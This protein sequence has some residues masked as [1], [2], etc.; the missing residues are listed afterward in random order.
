MNTNQRGILTLAYGKKRYVNMAK[1]LGRSLKLHNHGVPC[2]I[3]TDSDDPELKNLYDICI[4][5]NQ[6]FGKG[7]KQKLYIDNYSPFDE[8]IFIDSDCIVIKKIDFWDIFADVPFGVISEGKKQTGQAFWNTIPDVEKII[9][10]FQLESLT[11]FNGGLYYFKNNKD[12]AEV[13]KKAR[14]I[15]ANYD[16]IGLVRLRG[17]S[18]EEPIYSIALAVCGI[19][20]I[21]DR[22]LTMRTP[23][24]MIGS[25]EI[26]VLKGFCRFNSN[27]QIVEPAIMHFCGSQT[28]GF[29]YQREKLK[30]YLANQLPNINRHLIA[31]QINLIFLPFYPAAV[32]T[33]IL[34]RTVKRMLFPS[35][36]TA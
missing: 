1:V 28:S 29:Y 17:S 23:I 5:L 34:R 10:L 26:D 9:S 13:F 18:N 31:N 4:P 16:E 20:G 36:P 8:T 35:L 11:M 12:T 19:N 33:K 7:F 32:G 15:A 3:V 6:K 2:A 27:G 24:N 14:E 22:G 30:L 21:E 25:L